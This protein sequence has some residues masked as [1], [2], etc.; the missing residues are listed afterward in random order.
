MSWRSAG[1]VLNQAQDIAPDRA[2]CVTRHD[3]R[4]IAR[5]QRRVVVAERLPEEFQ[6]PHDAGL[7]RERQHEQRLAGAP[8]D[9]DR[10]RHMLER[11]DVALPGGEPVEGLERR[12]VAVRF[13]MA[14]VA[15]GRCQIV[16]QRQRDRAGLRDERGPR[17]ARLGV[18]RRARMNEIRLSHDR[19]C[20]VVKRCRPSWRISLNKPLCRMRNPADRPGIVKLLISKKS[21][22]VIPERDKARARNP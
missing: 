9:H 7:D 22:A 8:A 14:P 19:P 10:G 2:E 13:E 18:Q 5:Q 12:A 1:V 17:G 20:E 16:M 21:G 15:L 6:P 11:A 3:A 4:E